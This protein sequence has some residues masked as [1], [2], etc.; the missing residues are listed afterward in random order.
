MFVTASLRR[1]LSAAAVACVAAA[2]VLARPIAYAHSTTAMVEYRENALREAQ[3]FYAPEPWLSVGLG[4][5]EFDGHSGQH[6]VDIDYARINLLVKRWNLEGAQANVFA[7]GGL[8]QADIVEAVTAA[9]GGHNHG[10]PPPTTFREF[11]TQATNWGGQI[12][13]E[14]TR[15]YA[16]LKTDLQDTANYWH[17]VDTLELGI[18]PYR[19]EVNGLATWLVVAASNYAGNLHEGTETAVLLRFF[20]K[21]VWLEAGSTLDGEIRSNVMISF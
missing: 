7:W 17:R 15:L 2:P 6:Q 12:D 18:A 3:V 8:G 14:T 1:A 19:H 11:S 5:M 20:R 21:R 9:P 4:R 16:S 13:F 10:G